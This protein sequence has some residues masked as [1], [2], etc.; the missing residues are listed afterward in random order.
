ML[1]TWQEHRGGY[2]GV[3]ATGD[4]YSP[5]FHG[6][7]ELGTVLKW[8]KVAQSTNSTPGDKSFRC[9]QLPAVSD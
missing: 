2:I 8:T 1:A 3:K 7:I 9:D 4:T 6:I 5:F